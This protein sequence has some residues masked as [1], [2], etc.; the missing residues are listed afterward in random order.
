M[1]WSSNGHSL[2]FRAPTRDPNSTSMALSGQFHGTNLPRTQEEAW[3]AVPTFTGEKGSGLR[4][5][6]GGRR[7]G[8]DGT[9]MGY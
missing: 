3:R 8:S 6:K 7:T 4:V 2:R 9:T 5:P 1:V